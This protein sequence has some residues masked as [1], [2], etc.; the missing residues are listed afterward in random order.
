METTLIDNGQEK[1]IFNTNGNKYKLYLFNKD[2]NMYDFYKD[3]ATL[4][5][6]QAVTNRTY[7]KNKPKI[8]PV[9]VLVSS[10]HGK[11][12]KAKI[13]SIKKSRY[14]YNSFDAQT[15]FTDSKVRQLKD[16]IYKTFFKDNQHNNDLN[17]KIDE[18]QKALKDLLSLREEYTEEM[19][20]EHFKEL[21][22]FDE[23]N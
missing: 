10:N 3:Y 22:K 8:N 5:Q 15:T 1:I 6:A 16:F 11:L 14:G 21:I 23:E 9:F 18:T 12:V 13:T 2:V 19:A 17:K 20:K 4:E 7:K